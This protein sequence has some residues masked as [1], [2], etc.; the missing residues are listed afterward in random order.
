MTPMPQPDSYLSVSCIPHAT[1]ELLH[2]VMAQVLERPADGGMSYSAE[3]DELTYHLVLS[4][5]DRE[6]FPQ[7][8]GMTDI[9]VTTQA[10]RES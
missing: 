9:W 2:Y 1:N 7:I 10:R 8:S 4:D 6:M 5:F 3:K